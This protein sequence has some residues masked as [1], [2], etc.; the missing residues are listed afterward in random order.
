VSDLLSTTVAYFA[1]GAVSAA[2]F[3]LLYYY[4]T[5][6]S[7]PFLFLWSLSWAASL[8]NLLLL[9]SLTFVWR[10]EGPARHVLSFLATF[11]Q[12]C[13]LI[14]LLLGSSALSFHAKISR[15]RLLLWLALACV[16]AII[17]TIPFSFRE[18][19]YMQRYMLRVGFRY[20]SMFI[21][22]VVAGYWVGF[23][24]GVSRT[25]G[26]KLIAASFF[27]FAA[28]QLYYVS[29]IIGN[30][31]GFKIPLPGFFGMIEIVTISL[32]GLSMVIYLLED[33]HIR[34]TNANEELGNFLYRT[35]HDLRSPI[36]TILSIT[37]LAK[38]VL[39]EPDGLTYMSMVEDRSKKL[40][41]VIADILDLAQNKNKEIKL[42]QVD[43]NAL[44][45]DIFN[46]LEIKEPRDNAE[47]ISL[48]YKVLGQ[49]TLVTD[50]AYL[51]TVVFNIFKNSIKYRDKTK[52]H[53]FVGVEFKKTAEVVVITISDNGEGILPVC[54]PRI[55]EMFFRANTRAE[56]TGLGLYIVSNLIDKLNGKVTATSEYG[57]GT[58]ITV[59]LP[60]LERG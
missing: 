56:G 55:F 19:H 60:N 58:T 59:T 7:K 31:T 46:E 44:V 36:A 38:R 25:I 6:Y 11:A 24:Y 15:N 20:T 47:R 45:Q 13:Q 48:H 30:S 54:M 35:S 18:E 51:R 29:I 22:F 23:R 32:M 33:E 21:A 8:A 34:L 27:L 42:E 12:T 16:V 10:D 1:E 5:V 40:D 9:G 49:N 4:F 43:F 14:F 50:Y 52:E 53:S 2:L 17:V 57:K 39:K 28:Y 37:A 41:S 3:F 26:K